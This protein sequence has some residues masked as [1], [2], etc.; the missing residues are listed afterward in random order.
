MSAWPAIAA[1][2][3]R[4]LA[5]RGAAEAEIDDTLSALRPV[6]LAVERAGTRVDEDVAWGAP[7]VRGGPDEA[8]SAGGADGAGGEAEVFRCSR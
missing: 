5:L 1:S 7:R 3:R 4:A 6:V 8:G 2:L